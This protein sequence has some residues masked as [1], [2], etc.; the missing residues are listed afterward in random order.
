M[1]VFFNCHFWDTVLLLPFTD[2]VIIG[3]DVLVVAGTAQFLACTFT[4]T[5]VFG[6]VGGLGTNVAVI[7]GLAAFVGVAMNLWAVAVG[8]Y[9]VIGALLIL[10]SASVLTCLWLARLD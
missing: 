10:W 5:L 6:N 4:G 8:N 7:G 1:P 3:G 2:Q 9:G